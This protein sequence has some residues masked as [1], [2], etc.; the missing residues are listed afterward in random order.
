MN[1][2]DR[3]RQALAAWKKSQPDSFYASAPLLRT[4]HEEAWTPEE[5][6]KR[7]PGLVDFG[8]AAAEKLDA[9]VEENNRPLNLPQVAGWDGI[10][11]GRIR[12]PTIPVG[13][14]PTPIYG[15]GMMSAYGET[16][17]CRY[18]LSLFYLLPCR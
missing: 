13:E 4:L 5:L 11:A 9:C 6:A 14:K 8:R 10:G 7:L 16:P 17:S 18:I 12:F 1:S 2:T 15:S 3:G